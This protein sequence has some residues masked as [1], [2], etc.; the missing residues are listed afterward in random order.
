METH[1]H[2]TPRGRGGQGAPAGVA[3]A[4]V[5]EVPGK[6][7]AWQRAVPLKGRAFTPKSMRAAKRAVAMCGQLAMRGR[8]LLEGPVRLDIAAVYP[9]PKRGPQRYWRSAVPD[10]DNLAK[11]IADALEG[12]V[13]ANDRTVCRGLTDKIYGPRACTLVRVTPLA[14]ELSWA[15]GLVTP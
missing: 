6:P 4:I 8:P 9:H 11:L 2:K 12:V 13:Y 15:H 14:G 3:R 10:V 1:A 5:F 7:N